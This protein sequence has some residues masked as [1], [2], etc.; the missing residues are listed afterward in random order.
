ML[1]IKLFPNDVKSFNSKNKL[2]SKKNCEE[3]T[4]FLPKRQMQV[5][6]RIRGILLIVAEYKNEN[7][8]VC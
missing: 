7:I 4:I 3:I 5:I 2:N 6:S 1:V 8:C